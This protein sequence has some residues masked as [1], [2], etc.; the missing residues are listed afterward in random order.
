MATSIKGFSGAMR[1][2]ADAAATWG[3]QVT[4]PQTV[5][6]HTYT[7][8]NTYIWNSDS[9]LHLTPLNYPATVQMNSVTGVFVACT[10]NGTLTLDH[11]VSGAETIFYLTC[12]A[13]PGTAITLA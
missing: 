6:P 4:V 3:G 11:G 7:F 5:G 1:V 2:P 13:G 8:G 9:I 10:D 12:F